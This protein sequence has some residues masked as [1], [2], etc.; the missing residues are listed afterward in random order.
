MKIVNQF[1]TR[2]GEAPYV[3][4][5]FKITN[6]RRWREDSPLPLSPPFP[7]SVELISVITK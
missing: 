1:L 7:L 6:T 5:V 3:N 2:K 4:I